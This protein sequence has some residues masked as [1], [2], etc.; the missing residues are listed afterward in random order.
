VQLKATF[1]E[2]PPCCAFLE[3]F[4]VDESKTNKHL[5]VPESEKRDPDLDN[6]DPEIRKRANRRIRLL[7]M[8]EKARI[9]QV[10]TGLL[11]AEEK[12]K[13][14]NKKIEVKNIKNAHFYK[15]QRNW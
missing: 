1:G 7:R 3:K 2:N 12:K 15:K 10:F 14:I 9:E 4:T 13:A 5:V 8:A 6:P 11:K